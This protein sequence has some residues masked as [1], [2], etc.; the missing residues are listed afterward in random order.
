MPIPKQTSWSGRKNVGVLQLHPNRD[1]RNSHGMCRLVRQMGFARGHSSTRLPCLLL[2][3]HFGV[4]S[5]R[6]DLRLRPDTAT[7]TTA[8][9][10]LQRVSQ[11]REPMFPGNLALQPLHRTGAL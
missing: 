8:T 9:K 10:K 6:G 5:R 1:D 7:R 3:T 11:L 2:V 4:T